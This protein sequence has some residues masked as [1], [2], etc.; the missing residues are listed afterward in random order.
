M[1]DERRVPVVGC[2]VWPVVAL[3]KE[4]L[5]FSAF[6]GPFLTSFIIVN[7]VGG[8]GGGV[9]VMVQVAVSCGARV[10]EPVAPL[11]TTGVPPFFT[12]LQEAV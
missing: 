12:Q 8:G 6:L 9:L 3:Y 7:L 11:V 4:S 2:E 10:I 5:K 1:G